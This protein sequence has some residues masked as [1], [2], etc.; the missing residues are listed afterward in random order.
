VERKGSKASF[1]YIYIYI[2]EKKKKKK[3]AWSLVWVGLGS[4]CGGKMEG[5]GYGRPNSY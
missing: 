2:K 4:W 5:E 3:E 1:I